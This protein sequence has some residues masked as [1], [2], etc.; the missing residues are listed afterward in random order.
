MIDTGCQ[1]WLS[2]NLFAAEKAVAL[3]PDLADGYVAR[4]SIRT[5]M[6]WDWAGAQA[7]LEKALALRSRVHG[8]EVLTVSAPRTAAVGS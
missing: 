5:Q 8:S 6:T 1:S 7:D 2:K 3:A 4:G